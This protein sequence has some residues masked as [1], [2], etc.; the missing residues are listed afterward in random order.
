[1]EGRAH[2]RGT[3]ARKQQQSPKGAKGAVQLMN[4][5]A[6]DCPEKAERRRGEESGR[7]YSSPAQCQAAGIAGQPGLWLS[8]RLRI[9]V[10]IRA[11]H[12]GAAPG[13]PADAIAA[14]PA[15]T[16]LLSA[17]NDALEN[18][19]RLSNQTSNFDASLDEKWMLFPHHGL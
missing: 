3:A 15:T 16:W 12:G 11:R 5:A 4:N 10:Q 18:S 7:Q 14:P 17:T 8:A 2:T 6:S 19:A 9:P 1:M 13:R